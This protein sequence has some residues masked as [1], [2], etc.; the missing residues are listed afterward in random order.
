MSHI[1]DM[2]FSYVYLIFG[3]VFV[4]MEKRYF[5]MGWPVSSVL[6]YGFSIYHGHSKADTD[7]PW[8]LAMYVAYTLISNINRSFFVLL[9]L[10]W[11]YL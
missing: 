3:L 1:L 5:R 9:L 6:V 7:L 8:E 4:A 10:I 11:C 2:L